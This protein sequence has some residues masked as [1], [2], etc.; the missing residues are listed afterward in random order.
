MHA[1]SCRKD[2]SASVTLGNRHSKGHETNRE[3][4]AWSPEKVRAGGGG[5]KLV[6]F[7]KT[8][9]N[10]KNKKKYDLQHIHLKNLQQTDFFKLT[11]ARQEAETNAPCCCPCTQ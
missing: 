1:E 8:W 10:K 4:L 2:A 6:S 5:G 9:K 3:R 11:F 7:A